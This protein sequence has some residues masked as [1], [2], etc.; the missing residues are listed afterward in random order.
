MDS[1]T[2]A[3]W[4][5]CELANQMLANEVDLLRG[6]R[7]IVSLLPASG[8]VSDEAIAVVVGIE[9]ETDHFPESLEGWEPRAALRL[10]AER[11][12]YFASQRDVL[13]HACGEIVSKMGC[14]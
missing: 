8:W 1:M 10:S 2:A 13:L 6:V 3:R 12:L 4:Q 11:D 7:A 5:I 14:F 9:S